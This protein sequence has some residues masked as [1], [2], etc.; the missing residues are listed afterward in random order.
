MGTGMLENGLRDCAHCGMPFAPVR[1]GHLFCS[2][3]CQLRAYRVASKLRPAELLP[4]EAYGVRRCRV[5]GG[6]LLSRI[7][8]QV[9][10][11]TA[12]RHEWRNRQ[13]RAPAPALEVPALLECPR[14]GEPFAP[15]VR[16][17]RNVKVYCSRRCKQA[18]ASSRAEARLR[19][20]R[21]A[22][23]PPAPLAP[24]ECEWCGA[25][26]LPDKRGRRFCGGR[27]GAAAGSAAAAAVAAARGR[28]RCTVDGCEK[29]HAAKGFC[30]NHY[31]QWRRATDATLPP[32]AKWPS[33]R[34]AY[35]GVEYE[36][37]SPAAVFIADGWI[38][39]LCLEPVDPGCFFPDPLSPSLDH[40]VP[41]S[42]GGPHLRSNVQTAHLRC[43]IKKGNALA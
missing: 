36:P 35:W 7:A 24:R 4:D 12:C 22:Q 43:N 23:A 19:A 37:I 11:S 10:C 13:R 42:R 1:D 2:R 26:Y 14:C 3:T 21:P 5:C 9:Y 27:C 38:C 6:E 17:G 29:A 40:K 31:K 41:M 25:T 32:G 39:Q 20:S 15:V 28:R 16:G 34:A 30:H 18:Q 8:A 33:R